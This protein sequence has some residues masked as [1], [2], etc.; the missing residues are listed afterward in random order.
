MNSKQGWRSGTL[1]GL[2][3]VTVRKVSKPEQ[4]LA[5]NLWAQHQATQTEVL[6]GNHHQRKGRNPRNN[7]GI[8]EEAVR[9]IVGKWNTNIWQT[10]RERETAYTQGGVDNYT[11]LSH[12]RGD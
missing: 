10:H 9:R 8:H 1:L 12:I 6:Q 4:Y 2:A 5:E 11:Q 7:P 3:V